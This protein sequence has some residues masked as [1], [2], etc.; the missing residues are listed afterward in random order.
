MSESAIANLLNLLLIGELEIWAKF[1]EKGITILFF[2]FLQSGEYYNADLDK[3]GPIA[4]IK[5]AIIG[6]ASIGYEGMVWMMGGY[7]ELAEDNIVFSSVDCYNPRTNRY[8]WL[9]L[10]QTR[11][12]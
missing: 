5:E 11:S 8:K 6:S 2:R 12:V 7:L 4:N 9:S 3:W 1:S 10:N